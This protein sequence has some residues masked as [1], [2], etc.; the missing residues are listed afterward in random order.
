MDEISVT[1]PGERS[2]GAVAGLVL[3]G[4]AARHDLTLDV[5]DDLHLALEGLLDRDA[6][7]GELTIV[8]RVGPETIEASVGPFEPRSISELDDDAGE[9]LDLRRLLDT[10]VDGFTVSERDGGSW[11]ELRKRY[12]LAGRR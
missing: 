8:F 7:D 9:Q 6:E 1:I 12:D 2:F 3:G 4:V 10:V 5:L 11:V